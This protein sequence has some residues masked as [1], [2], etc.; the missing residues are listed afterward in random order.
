MPHVLSS[1]LVFL[2]VVAYVIPG[3]GRAKSERASQECRNGERR[4]PRMQQIF[5]RG[6]LGWFVFLLLSQERWRIFLT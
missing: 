3:V 6:A 4:V 1:G 5:S 2:F